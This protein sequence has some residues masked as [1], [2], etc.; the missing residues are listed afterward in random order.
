V[1]QAAKGT[2]IQKVKGVVMKKDGLQRVLEFLDFLR[3]KGIE[4]RID[5]QAPD[6]LI[7]TF[8]LVGARVEATFDVDMMHFSVFKGSEAVETDEKV[9]HDLIKE[10]WDD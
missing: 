8:A 10:H 5:Q 7:V 2:E 6:E 9:L 1:C 3:S 4:F